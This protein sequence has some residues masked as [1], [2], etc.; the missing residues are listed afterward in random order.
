[1]FQFHINYSQFDDLYLVN[2]NAKEEK[3]K[4]TNKYHFQTTQNRRSCQQ[5]SSISILH[6]IFYVVEYVNTHCYGDK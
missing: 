2:A 5:Y 3:R 1:M 6:L 4:T